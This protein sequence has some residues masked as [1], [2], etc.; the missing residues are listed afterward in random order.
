MAPGQK[1][2]ADTDRAAKRPR[3]PEDDPDYAVKTK[4]LYDLSS[5]NE[6]F[7]K[8]DLDTSTV[9]LTQDL[10]P[11]KEDETPLA[12]RRS[13][14]TLS[15]EQKFDLLTAFQRIQKLPT[16]NPNSFF[17]LGGYHGMPPVKNAFGESKSWNG[18]CNHGN[19]LFPTWH[20]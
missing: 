7:Y 3:D 8:Q 5:K 15:P 11:V 6:K 12:V 20:R 9:C 17:A 13:I 1:N 19:V 16:D 18:W 10:T 14:T 2:K 4:K